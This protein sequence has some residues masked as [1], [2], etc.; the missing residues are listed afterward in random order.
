MSYWSKPTAPRDDLRLLQVE[1]DAEG[2]ALTMAET[3]ANVR[4]TEPPLAISFALLV[5]LFAVMVLFGAAVPS[6]GSGL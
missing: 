3:L 4:R 2:R 5:G 1:F 6:I